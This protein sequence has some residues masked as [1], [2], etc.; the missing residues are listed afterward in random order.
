MGVVLDGG[1]ASGLLPALQALTALAVVAALVWLGRRALSTARSGRT[2]S[3]SMHVEERIGLD[4]KNALVIVRVGERR[5]LLA[6][7]ERGPA[8]LIAE[9]A[10]P[11]LADALPREPSVRT[12]A[13]PKERA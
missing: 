6:T 13:T 3:A 9:L 8:R 11:T 1:Q 2:G 5:M 10:M 7:S 12:D 4:L